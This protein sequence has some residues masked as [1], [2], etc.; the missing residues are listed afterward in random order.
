M[1]R[2]YFYIGISIITIL[3][4]LTIVRYLIPSDP[5]PDRIIPGDDITNGQELDSMPTD[6]DSDT[7]GETAP[8]TSNS[9]SAPV[10]TNFSA[11]MSEWSMRVNKKTF[12]TYVSPNNSPVSPEKFTGYHA[13]IDLEILA[14]EETSQVPV[15]AICSGKLAIK[16]QASGYGGLV[17]QYCD[18]NGVQVLVLYGHVALSSVGKNVGDDVVIGEQLALL[19]QPGTDTDGERK[20]LHLGIRKGTD[21]VI[22][23]YVANQASLSAF[24]DPRELLQ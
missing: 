24:Y 21:L 20:H 23:G 10:V 19:G 14:G 11:P 2:S 5:I 3:I 8:D 18:Y 17:A 16:R 4:M 9:D 12:G 22:S 13:A 7:D 15:L 1:P 6:S